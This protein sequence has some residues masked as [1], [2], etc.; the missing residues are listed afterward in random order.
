MA[1]STVNKSQTIVTP[2][3][4]TGTGSE[5]RALTGFGHQTDLFWVFRRDGAMNPSINDSVQGATQ[6]IYSDRDQGADTSTQAITYGTDGI[7]WNGGNYDRN[8]N[9]ANYLALSWK[10]GTT[11]GISAGS[12]TITPASYSINVDAGFGIYQ[13]TGNGSSTQTISHGLGV[14]PTFMMIKRINGGNSNWGVYHKNSGADVRL[15]LNSTAAAQSNANTWQ[16]T[17]PTSTVFTVGSNSRVNDNGQEYIA[18]VWANKNGCFHAGQYRGNGESSDGPFI[19]TGFKPGIILFKDNG[20]TTNWTVRNVATD[21]FNP[22]RNY[23][24]PN[25]NTAGTDIGPPATTGGETTT[26]CATG[27]KLRG[28]NDSYFNQSNQTYVYA[29]WPIENLV[30]GTNNI[31]NVAGLTSN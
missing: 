31:P 25:T 27:F 1:Y 13:Y 29:A 8:D 26:I 3:I 5:P 14:A 17:D 15:T 16:D 2:N 12:Q 28:T 6:W 9:G 7:T 30:G 23:N 11:S 21:T 24:F 19:Y 10:A 18:Y 20:A 22:I 4:Y